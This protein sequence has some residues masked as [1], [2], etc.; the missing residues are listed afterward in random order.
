M[1]NERQKELPVPHVSDLHKLREELL[2]ERE[3]AAKKAKKE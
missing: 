3:E 1:D 2:R